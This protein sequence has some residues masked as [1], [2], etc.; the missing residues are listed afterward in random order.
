MF[1]GEE[2]LRACVHPVHAWCIGFV[3]YLFLVK[4]SLSVVKVGS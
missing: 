3:A 4:Q 1:K 2:L